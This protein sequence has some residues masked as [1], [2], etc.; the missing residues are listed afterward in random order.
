MR[1]AAFAL[2]GCL[3]GCSLT[4]GGSNG[5]CSRD[6]Q[7]GDDVCARSNEC[8]SRSAVRPV[9]V[10]WTINGAAADATACAAHPNLYVQFESADYGDTLRIAPVPCQD[11]AYTIDKVPKRYLQVELGFQGGASDISPIESAQVQ[12]DLFQ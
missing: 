8:M 4:T 11:G 1:I 2:L 9:A 7:C 5:E 10:R 3:A 12:F 6:S